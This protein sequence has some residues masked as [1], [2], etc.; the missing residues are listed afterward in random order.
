MNTLIVEDCPVY[1][2]IVCELLRRN[3]PALA[4]S[5]AE[6]GREA[7]ERVRTTDPRLIFMDL[8]LPDANGLHLTREIREQDPGREVVIITASD[9]LEYRQAANALGVQHFLVKGTS[10][11]HELLEVTTAVLAG[12]RARDEAAA[13]AA[14]RSDLVSALV[15]GV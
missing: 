9:L 3:F 10:T 11:P 4:L 5:E 1:R 2:Q 6:D 12:K 8:N 7:L 14:R 15:R 13:P